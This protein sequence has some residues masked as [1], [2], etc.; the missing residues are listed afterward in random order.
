MPAASST[1]RGD[2][3]FR[4]EDLPPDALYWHGRLKEAIV[5]GDAYI[6]QHSRSDDLYRIGRTVGDYNSA[7]I[8]ALRATGDLS[9]L[10]R[11]VEIC[12]NIR[13]DLADAWD[14]GTTDGYLNWRWRKEPATYYGNDL[15]RTDELFTHMNLAMVAY[16]FEVNRDLKPA[17]AEQADF[18]K[19]YLLDHFLP[20]WTERAGGDPIAAWNTGD[21]FWRRT[22]SPRAQQLRGAYYLYKLTGDSFFLD[23]A[24]ECAADVVHFAQINPAVPTAYRWKHAISGTDEGW[25]RVNYANYLMRAVLEMNLEGYT[26]WR[27]DSEMERYAS[28]F[29]DVVWTST[30]APFDTMTYRVSGEGETQTRL[31]CMAGLARWDPTGKILALADVRWAA[32]PYGVSIAAY[33]LAAVSP[34]LARKSD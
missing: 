13:A 1:L 32:H 14:D 33:A 6:Q 11:V 26:D 3:T 28:T 23:R 22:T 24:E 27:L 34:R 18:W 10:D 16:T 29:R 4:L 5:G 15:H 19:S 20:K 12:N 2:P 30:V 8:M 21:G 7:L 25:Q 9:F 31:Y 17:Y